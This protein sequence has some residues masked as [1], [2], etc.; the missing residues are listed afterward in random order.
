MEPSDQL[1]AADRW[2]EAGDRFK[3]VP[4]NRPVTRGARSSEHNLQRRVLVG[5]I[6]SM[7]ACIVLLPVA[8]QGV[9]A[10]ID[11][12]VS[13][14]PAPFRGSDGQTHLAYELA[15]T[16]LSGTGRAKLERVEVF[17]D[18]Q[19]EPLVSYADSDLDQRA[20]R[21][22][23]DRETR[24]GRQVPGG[25]TTLI[26]VWISLGANRAVPRRLRHS[27]VISAEDG[28]R[29]EAGDARVD[30]QG[31]PLVIG[32]PFRTGAWLAHNGPGQHRSSHWGSAL[33][34]TQGA[35]IPQ[36][37][38]ID[39][40]GVDNDGRAVRGDFQKSVNEDWIGFGQEVLAA[41]DGVVHAARD[42]VADNPPLVELPRTTSPSAEGTYGN[43]VIIAAAG[44]TFVHYAHLQ[45]N[46]VMVKTGQAVRRGQL[47]GRLGNSGNTNAAHLHF[48][49]TD[50]PLAEG[51]QGV[52]FVFD[53]FEWLGRTTAGRALGAEPSAEVFTFSPSTRSKEL[54]L[55]GVVVRYR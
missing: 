19:T 5:S 41:A 8:G 43:Y 16:G 1:A 28:S 37:Y 31:P 29:V 30:V 11:V 42:G 40:M 46:S 36:R 55:D 49:V 32:A 7:I 3:Y 4:Y 34:S 15:L 14:A 23:A 53:A 26:H 45:H 50:G 27:L 48:N 18:A 25:T 6:A 13:V 47:L 22:E 2:A 35:L 10:R 54:T 38:A 39:F 12:R 20:M 24:Y 33:V 52:P 44:R 51:A 17:G 9:R 21:P